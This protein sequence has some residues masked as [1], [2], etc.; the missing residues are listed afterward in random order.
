MIKQSGGLFEEIWIYIVPIEQA[1]K[2]GSIALSQLGSLTHFPRGDLK[3][4]AEIISFE[5]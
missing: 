2:L 5:A 1:I 4:V 3:Q